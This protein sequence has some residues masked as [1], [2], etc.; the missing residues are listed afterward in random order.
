MGGPDMEIHAVQ[1]YRLHTRRS[2][3]S[4]QSSTGAQSP[5]LVVLGG[6]WVP[7]KYTLPASHPSPSVHDSSTGHP[8]Q[9]TQ[10]YQTAALPQD[11]YLACISN[12]TS[13]APVQMHR[14]PLFESQQ[15][16]S[17]SQTSPQ[18]QAKSLNSTSYKDQKTCF[19][20]I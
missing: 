20:R 14:Q 18:V 12:G 7:P 13:E 3:S 8:S 10:F 5:Q 1:K 11:H 4:P 19:K 17:Q 15:A 6:I 2:S 9:P 16:A